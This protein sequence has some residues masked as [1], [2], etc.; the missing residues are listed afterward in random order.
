MQIIIDR[1]LPEDAI[2]LIK[3]QNICF[4]EDYEKYNECPAYQ[5]S[6]D[7][8]LDMIK[9]AIVYKI[10]IDNQIIGDIIVR[11]RSETHYYLRTIS[12]IPA[13]Q[14][15]G[16]GKKAIEFIE[17]DNPD[18]II[19]SLITPNG[20]VRN[21]HFYERLGYK[22]IGEEIKSDKLTLI[23]YQKEILL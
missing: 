11:K 19:W 16:I 10:V 20:N 13:Y 17:K 5:E 18:G 23:K 12:V 6:V 15:L 7:N 2:E 9:N 3:V 8:M 14:N 22:K 1:S 4:Q 21:L